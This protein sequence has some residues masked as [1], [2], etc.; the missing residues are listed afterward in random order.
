MAIP[1]I[2]NAFAV[3]CAFTAVLLGFEIYV[4]NANVDDPNTAVEVSN[5]SSQMLTLQKLEVL[6]FIMITGTPQSCLLRQCMK[7]MGGNFAVP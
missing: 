4:G 1:Y 2:Q 5:V 7:N 6:Y 3:C